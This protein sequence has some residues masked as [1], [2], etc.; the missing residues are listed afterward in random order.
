MEKRLIKILERI[1]GFLLAAMVL[2]LSIQIITR[3]IFRGSLLW[4][5][6]IAV[7]LFVWVSLLGSVVLF[8][9][10]KHIVIDILT[11]FLPKKVN[12]ILAKFNKLIVF[13]FFALVF[14]YSIPVVKSYSSQTATSIALSKFFLF[15]P[16]SVASFLILAYMFLAFV[17]GILRRP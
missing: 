16:L 7:W 6:E 14:Y 3:Y 8:I 9:N 13:V 2:L 15:V 11:A 12:I 5:G 10:N 17:K 4:A 1:C